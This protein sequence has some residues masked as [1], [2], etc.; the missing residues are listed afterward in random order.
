MK[1]LYKGFS[2]HNYSSL[3]GTFSVTDKDLVNLDILSHL[4]TETDERVMM[5]GFGTDIPNKPFEPLTNDL[6][7]DVYD[8]ITR[9]VDYDPRVKRI[10]VSVVPYHD[11]NALVCSVSLLYIELNDT[12]SFDFVLNLETG[13]A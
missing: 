1:V 12:D 5:P 4:Y 8:D 11:A 3:G 13:N 6:I 7:E 10:T 2:T 9:V